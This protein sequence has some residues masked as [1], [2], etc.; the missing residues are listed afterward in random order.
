MGV[1]RVWLGPGTWV[2]ERVWRTNGETADAIP[3]HSR[4]QHSLLCPSLRSHLSAL[5]LPPWPTHHG[6]RAAA[7]ATTVSQRQR[8]D[9]NLK[10]RADFFLLPLQLQLCCAVCD[11]S[12][13]APLSQTCWACWCPTPTGSA[14][15]VSHR[16]LQRS[17]TGPSKLINNR[18]D[19]IIG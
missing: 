18:T 3:F 6:T 14:W 16:E 17:S 8:N 5:P 2:R 15:E 13:S 1:H 19:Q 10:E 11:V 9:R 4:S 12:V 7:T